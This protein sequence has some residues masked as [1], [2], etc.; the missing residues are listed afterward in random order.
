MS[1][2][3]S[4]QTGQLKYLMFDTFI[5]SIFVRYLR[6]YQTKNNK[7]LLELV[8]KLQH[9]NHERVARKATSQQTNPLGLEDLSAIRQN[10]LKSANSASL[11]SPEV[12]LDQMY[13][14]EYWRNTDPISNGVGSGMAASSSID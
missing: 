13:F 14:F 10:I 2:I 4:L 3:H 7:P 12:F 9:W 8:P 6:S 11:K 5:A 1:K